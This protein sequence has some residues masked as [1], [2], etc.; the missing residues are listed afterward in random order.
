MS[1]KEGTRSEEKGSG[2]QAAPDKVPPALGSSA[3][4]AQDNLVTN[5]T[6]PRPFPSP[7]GE[8]PEAVEVEL[9]AHTFKHPVAEERSAVR[10][11]QLLVVGVLPFSRPALMHDQNHN[12][13]PP[14]QEKYPNSSFK[15]VGRRI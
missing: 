8:E 4:Q 12:A 5:T 14:L 3:D 10:Q 13:Q 15:V 11:Q 9:M 6:L 2:G 7:A 1:T